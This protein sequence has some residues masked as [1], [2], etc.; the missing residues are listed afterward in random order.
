MC[1]LSYM[2]R[3][4]EKNRMNIIMYSSLAVFILFVYHVLSDGDFSFLLVRQRE[5][6]VCATAIH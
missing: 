2:R 5:R 3:T 6:S 4:I 1:L